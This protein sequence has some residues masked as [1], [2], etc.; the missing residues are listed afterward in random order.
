MRSGRNLPGAITP[1]WPGRLAIPALTLSAVDTTNNQLV[2]GTFTLVSGSGT[3]TIRSGTTVDNVVVTIR[4][5]TTVTGPAQ[6]LCDPDIV[7]AIERAASG[8]LGRPW[9]SQ[10]LTDL[11]DR[12]SH[13]CGVLHG[14]P[15]SVFAKFSGA[16]DA[17]DQFTAELA[18]LQTLTRLAGIDTPVP[19]AGGVVELTDGCLL[20]SEALPEVLP[21]D[22][23]RGQWRSIG[24]VLAALHKTTHPQFGLGE[25][26]GFFGPLPQ[27]NRPVPT[28]RWSDFYRERRIAPLLRRAV[29]SGH[30]PA[31]LAAGV[32]RIAARL[33]D[34]AG[35]DPQPSLLHGDAQQNNFV[36]TA[37]A[38][39]VIDAAPYFGHPE[40]DLALL[41]FFQPVPEDV[42]D[43][44][45]ER[46]P[47]DPG[48]P[49]RKQL[50]RLPS[51][52]AIITVDG[53]QPEGLAAI[54]KLAGAI[55][56]FG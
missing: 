9:L 44:Y 11:G 49:E 52:L 8:H 2:A 31:D 36:T 42:L 53:R 15:F 17:R 19:V 4:G 6:P 47:I 1:S 56:T 28:N 39:V 40:I 10:G 13:P 51:Y 5:Y 37:T 33:P 23:G 32:D 24:Q 18:G 3:L 46:A 34:I 38:A 27:D 7:T 48:F 12:A 20:L 41:D 21:R 22:R 54:K 50:W 26:P 45:S 29:D 14:Q 55:S 35:P 30:L 16:A 25:Q 43:A